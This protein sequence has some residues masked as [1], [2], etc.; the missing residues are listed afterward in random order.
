MYP[1]IQRGTDNAQCMPKFA[2][3]P[4]I[5]K[6]CGL[7]MIY[8]SIEFKESSISLRNKIPLSAQ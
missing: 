2:H 4:E 1:S 7:P 3:F 8:R 6:H 5:P